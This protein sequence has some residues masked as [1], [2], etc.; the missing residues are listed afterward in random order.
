MPASCFKFPAYCFQSFHPAYCSSV[1]SYPFL[2]QLTNLLRINWGR[3]VISLW[4]KAM[5]ELTAS[6]SYWTSS[7]ASHGTGWGGYAALYCWPPALFGCNVPAASMQWLGQPCLSARWTSVH[8]DGV[9]YRFHPF[10]NLV[11][12]VVTY[13]LRIRLPTRVGSLHNL[14]QCSLILLTLEDSVNE[15]VNMS[16]TPSSLLRDGISCNR[17]CVDL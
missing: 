5:C 13:Y 16:Q 7:K 4:K 1:V 11:N 15:T 9:C 10:V 12:V 17:F 2:L 14:V 3:E 8:I 6:S